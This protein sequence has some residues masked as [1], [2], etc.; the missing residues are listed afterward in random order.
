MGIT[1]AA[2]GAGG[3]VAVIHVTGADITCKNPKPE[4]HGIG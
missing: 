3:I 4:Q 2:A 1:I